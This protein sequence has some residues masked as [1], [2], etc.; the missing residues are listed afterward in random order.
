[1]I[2][3]WRPMLRAGGTAIGAFAGERLAGLAVLRVGLRAD[4]AQLAALFV[5]RANRRLGVAG[6]LVDEVERLARVD[7]ARFLYVSATPSRSAVGFYRSRGF[8]PVAEPDPD[9]FALEPEDVHMIE[10]L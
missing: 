3:S 10:P 2:D 6:A 1:M 9:L 4:T 7:G 8:E 5:D